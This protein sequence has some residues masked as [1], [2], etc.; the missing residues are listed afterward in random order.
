MLKT[1]LHC[2]AMLTA[3]IVLPV[4]TPQAGAEPDIAAGKQIAE[5]QC[6]RCHAIGRDDESALPAA[7]PLRTLAS[8]W[9]LDVLDEAFAEGI[10]TGHAD[11]PEFR[12]QPKQIT[13]LLG[14]IQ[15]ISP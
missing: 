8:K 2:A 10:V 1:T 12:F 13:D 15:S 5:T 7:P 3:F 11:M 4:F 9:P 6:A 14:Y